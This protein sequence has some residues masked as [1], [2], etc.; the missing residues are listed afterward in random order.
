MRQ[1]GKCCVTS[2]F[3]LELTGLRFERVKQMA[4]ADYLYNSLGDKANQLTRLTPSTDAEIKERISASTS[5]CTTEL[6]EDTFRLSIVFESFHHQAKISISNKA[7]LAG[8]L[9]LSLKRCTMS[10][11]FHEIIVADVV[12]LAVL[13]AFGQS[14]ALL[15]MMVG[16]IQSRLWV[17]TKTFCKVKVLVDNDGNVLIDQH[18]DPEVRLPNSKVEVLYTYLVARYVMHCPS[19][20]TAAY[21]S[22]DFV[23]FF[24]SWSARLGSI[25]I[26]FTLGGPF[27]ATLIVSW[28]DT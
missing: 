6:V 11:L 21:I 17:L 9:M 27:R 22:E 7:L 1:I 25:P 13:L 15:P 10:T 19:L 26:Y 8:F 2:T 12:Y 4:C 24:R 16:C 14:I 28:S 18:G 3:A 20:M 5:S 23:P